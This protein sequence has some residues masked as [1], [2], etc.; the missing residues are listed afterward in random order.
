[1][2]VRLNDGTVRCTDHFDASTYASLTDDPCLYCEGDSVTTITHMTQHTPDGT[3]H[4]HSRVTESSANALEHVNAMEAGHDA[5][6]TTGHG[7]WRWVWEYVTPSGVRCS[8]SVWIICK[9]MVRS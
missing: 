7:W 9:W 2:N 4:L 3:Q 1:M 8:D 6:Y 5:V